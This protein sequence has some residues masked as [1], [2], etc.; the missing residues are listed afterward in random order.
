MYRVSDLKSGYSGLIGWRQNQ[1]TS[2][3]QIAN[4]LTA[5]S[6]GLYF[7][8]FHPLLNI[9]ILEQY[10]PEFE[11]GTYTAYDS[12]T[13]YAVG[14]KASYSSVNYRCIKAGTGNQPDT[15][16][17]YWEVYT[18]FS[19]WLQE[20]T[21]A[22][23]A[24]MLQNL[25]TQKIADRTA[26]NILEHK[27]LFDRP[28]RLA[29]TIDNGNYLVGFEITPLRSDSVTL[30]IDKI[31]AQFEGVEDLTLYLFHSSQLAPVQTIILNRAKDK[32]LEWFTPSEEIYLPYLSEDTDAGGTWYL[33]YDQRALGETVKAIKK[34]RD[35]SK[36]PCGSCNSSEMIAQKTWSRYL[37]IYPFKNGNDFDSGDPE[38]FDISDNLYDLQ[39]N[40][41]LNLQ[42]TLECDA[43][44]TLIEQRRSFQN[45]LGLQVAA[46]LL[47]YMAYNPSNNIN[48]KTHNTSVQQILYELDGDSQGHKK[49]GLNYELGKAMEAASVDLNGMS[50][51][52]Y[53]CNRK[54]V[55]YRT[56]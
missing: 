54:G 49:S 46:D 45:L 44:D 30:K 16:A 37:E 24:K 18:P 9:E 27:A 7:Q 34:D 21:E 17:E 8:D 38:L 50:R 26:K 52:C 43:T 5:S 55:K 53:S 39:T 15:S 11:E 2:T 29:D 19:E 36:R 4:S 42:I 23:I 35:W 47:R 1:K 25:W 51:V 28:G 22:S 10:A 20:Q 31:G 48:R 14:D 40:Y 13:A 6:S 41:G 33:C 32:S 3:L 56:I 12:G